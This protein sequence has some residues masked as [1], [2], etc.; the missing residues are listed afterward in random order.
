MESPAWSGVTE[1]AK[2]FVKTLLTWDQNK[3]PTAGQALEHFWIETQARRATTAE[4]RQNAVAALTNLESFDAHSKLRV[5]TCTFIASQLMDKQE[6]ERIDDAFRAMGEYL[7]SAV[8]P[9][10][11]WGDET[12]QLCRNIKLGNRHAECLPAFALDLNSQ[13]N[14]VLETITD[15]NNDGTLD[16]WEVQQGYSKFFGREISDE[17]VDHIFK[18]VDADGTGELEYS[19]FLFGALDKQNLLSAE[20]LKKAFSI[21]DQDGSGDISLLELKE[22]LRE[23][24]TF[25]DSVDEKA[26]NNMISQVDLDGDGRISY[27]EFVTMALGAPPDK[28]ASSPP[29]PDVSEE[30]GLEGGN[31]MRPLSG[32]ESSDSHPLSTIEEASETSHNLPAMISRASQSQA[33]ARSRRDPPMLRHGREDP[34]SDIVLPPKVRDPSG[35]MRLAASFG[36]DRLKAIPSEESPAIDPTEVSFRD[37][38]VQERPRQKPSVVRT[39]RLASRASKIDEACEGF[40][41]V[42]E[43]IARLRMLISAKEE[44]N[45]RKQEA[46]KSSTVIGQRLPQ[47]RRPNVET[48]DSAFTKLAQI[49]SKMRALQAL[50]KSNQI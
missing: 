32:T 13:L 41:R 40:D 5:A 17:E 10:L 42:Q 37:A 27:E 30:K 33:N 47:K 48:L 29:S 22:L 43:K 46:Q 23:A 4:L 26:L 25:D 11:W 38:S 2:D 44:S 36:R 15:L 19:E 45:R 39:P 7:D 18:H 9:Y 31:Q 6:K 8:F 14:V 24:L 50:V 12:H 20:N 16:K 35:G 21:F 28:L 34:P 49:Q 3:R 1:L